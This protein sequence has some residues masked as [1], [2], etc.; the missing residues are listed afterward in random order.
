M[1]RRAKTIAKGA[2][3]LIKPALGDALM[4]L[5][6]DGVEPSRAALIAVIEAKL[7]KCPS[8]AGDSAREQDLL[9]LALEQ[10]LA[11]LQPSLD[12]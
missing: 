4:E 2:P 5:L 11:V 10:T 12:R 9:R 3:A 6:Q 8:V 7:K 1:E